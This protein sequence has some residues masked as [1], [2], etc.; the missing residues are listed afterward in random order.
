MPKKRKPAVRRGRSA[1]MESGSQGDPPGVQLCLT[2][3]CD[4]GDDAFGCDDCE[5][6]VHNTVMCSGLTEELIDAIGKYG[7]ANIKYVCTKCRV[8]HSSA[9]S[10]SPSSTTESH[11]SELVQQLFQ[12]MTGICQ[13]VK[14]LSAQVKNL[15][16]SPIQTGPQQQPAQPGATRPPAQNPSRYPDHDSIQST[17]RNEIKEMSER[18][19]RRPFIIVR[20]LAAS[21]PRDF[22]S[23]FKVITHE[24]MQKDIPLTDVSSFA[25]HPGLF[26]AKIVNDDDRKALL[27]KAKSLKDTA[28]EG[29]FITRDLTYAQRTELYNRRQARRNQESHNPQ[30]SPTSGTD[31]AESATAGASTQASSAQHPTT[32]QPG[33]QGN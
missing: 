1:S 12:Q 24:L 3:S 14:E 23:K 7:G 17:I 11:M 31:Q 32:T 27:D 5:R 15:S 21:S 16:A 4:V 28:N 6:W 8:G 22:E 19:K 9:K 26:R 30:A 13:V 10:R 25:K 2:C 29:V 20:G 33:T 18:E